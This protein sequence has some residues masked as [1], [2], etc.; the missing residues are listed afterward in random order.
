M[1]E[2]WA[3]VLAAGESTRMKTNKLLLPYHGRLIITSVIERAMQSQASQVLLV[4]GA[5]RE[6]I[7]QAVE[8]LPVRNCYNPDY[9]N[10]MLS[11]VQCGFRNIPEGTCAAIVFL[12]DQPMVSADAVN[13]LIQAYRLTDKGILVPV[14]NGRRGHPVM[15]DMKY[16]DAV[17]KLGPDD[18]L[19]TLMQEFQADV[20]EVMVEVPGILQDI[21]TPDDYWKETKIN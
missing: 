1:Y 9:K 16:R 6:E 7:L 5:F 18:S 20:L 19:R 4:L 17:E 3:L 15:I 11:S 10:G 21:D 8:G 2:I 14:Y 13:S 12:G